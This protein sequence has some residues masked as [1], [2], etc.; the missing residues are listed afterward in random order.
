MDA[1]TRETMI[2]EL[3]RS[4]GPTWMQLA[5]L[6]KTPSVLLLGETWVV[7]NNF[8]A[9]RTAVEFLPAEE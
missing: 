9:T 7:A 8:E 5:R 2:E 6:D 3:L 1:V 4:P